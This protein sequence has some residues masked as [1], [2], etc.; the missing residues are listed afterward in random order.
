[1]NIQN[2]VIA[3]IPA[4]KG[5]KTLADKNV[6]DLKN[7]PVLAYS[8]AAAKLSQSISRVIVSTNSKKYSE[9]A[10]HYGAEV[11]FLR[12]E[13][14]STDISTDREFLLHA[15]EF[16]EKEEGSLP[17]YWVHLRPTTPLRVPEKIDLAINTIMTKKESTSL[18][19]GHKAPES[20]LKWFRIENKELFIPFDIPDAKKEFFN[21]PKEGFEDVYIPNGY[22]DVLKSSHVLNH[23]TIYGDKMLA[24]KS[25]VCSEID[26]SEEF[27]FI[28]HQLSK[29]GSPLLDYLNKT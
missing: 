1:M 17:E 13:E 7:H 16:L 10:T 25:P 28:E 9:I 27:D 4:R 14:H 15:M 18:R 8:I 23:E 3:V 2:S 24:F 12:P 5:S 20:P 6:I 22:V 19:S 29:Y 26:S 21:L 11:P